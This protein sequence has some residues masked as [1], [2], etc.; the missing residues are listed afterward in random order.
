MRKYDKDKGTTLCRRCDPAVG[1]YSYDT[2]Y[3]SGG[4]MRGRVRT[5]LQCQHKVLEAYVPAEGN[6]PYWLK[7]LGGKRPNLFNAI[8]RTDYWGEEKA[9]V[10]EDSGSTDGKLSP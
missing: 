9:E 10:S 2:I 7:L 1:T 4:K 6:P 3:D 5:C 8:E